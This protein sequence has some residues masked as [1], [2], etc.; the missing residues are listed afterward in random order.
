LIPMHV[1]C[2]DRLDLYERFRTEIGGQLSA[3]QVVAPTR[4]GESFRYR[5]GKMQS[6]N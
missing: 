4:I 3:T 1:G 6:G 2:S 5:S